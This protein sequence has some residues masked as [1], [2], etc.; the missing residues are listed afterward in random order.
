MQSINDDMDELYRKAGENYPLK[1]D[2]ANWDKVLQQL[3][4]DAP[5]VERGA[6]KGR[7]LW[8]LLL[9]P[10]FFVCNRYSGINFFGDKGV[11][12]SSGT[13]SEGV[14]KDE[15]VKSV[16]KKDIV[17]KT[18]NSENHNDD[19][20]SDDKNIVSTTDKDD[21]FKLLTRKYYTPSHVAKTKWHRRDNFSLDKSSSRNSA[22]MQQK[23]IELKEEAVSEDEVVNSYDN[24][25]KTT[26]GKSHSKE[27]DTP[28][29]TQNKIDLAAKKNMDSLQQTTTVSE[30]KQP[31]KKESKIYY[32]FIVG[33]DI[34]TVKMQKVEG[35]GYN[36]GVIA[37]YKIKDRLSIEAGFIWNNKKYYSKGK[38][39]DAKNMNWPQHTELVRIDGYCNMYEIPVNVRYD[40]RIKGE[41]KFFATAGS[42]SYLMNKESYNYVVQRY[43]MT[44]PG[45][46]EYGHSTKDWFSVVNLSVG[47]QKTLGKIGDL[48]IEPYFKIPVSGLGIGSLPISSTGINFGLTRPLR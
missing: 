43:G 41:H 26:T 38:Y 20:K 8:L 17:A 13:S 32:G 25:V 19:K 21:D 45:S 27:G 46:K 14:Q 15:L 36:F 42:S 16:G 34:S 37:G 44:Y 35:L 33:A 10:M 31:E 47:Y 40:W 30:K 7:F 1:T 2:G 24:S 9:L 48:R 28:D 39:F 11:G 29:T 6:K 18:T 12:K 3:Q 5:V 23:D 22:G 4:A